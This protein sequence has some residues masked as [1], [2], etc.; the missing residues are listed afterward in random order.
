[1]KKYNKK[2]KVNAKE[3]TERTAGRAEQA[4]K[5]N[6]I[7]KSILGVILTISIAVFLFVV[8]SNSLGNFTYKGVKFEKVKFCDSQPCLVTYKTSLPVRVNGTIIKVAYPY[9]KTNDY[10]FYLRNDPRELN[11]EFDG[12]ITLKEI[13]VLNADDSLSCEGKGVIGTANINRLYQILGTE[14][15]RD[16]NATCDLLGRYSLVTVQ[17]GNKTSIEK[18]GPACYNINIKD[19]EVLEGTEKFMVETLIK[20]NKILKNETVLS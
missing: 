13:M 3:A 2:A 18:I 19:C 16:E 12:N 17:P 7:L 11:V 9:Q 5:E 1:M 4:R 6:K 20:I 8:I 14:V 15:I 10:N